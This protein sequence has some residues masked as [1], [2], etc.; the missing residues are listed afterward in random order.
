MMQRNGKILHT[1]VL[2]GLIL[3]KMVILPK[4]SLNSQCDPY[5]ITYDIF[6]RIIN[7]RN[8]PKMYMEPEKT[9]S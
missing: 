5:Q 1:T 8:T 7:K 4:G 2:E 6:H 9:Q 3:L